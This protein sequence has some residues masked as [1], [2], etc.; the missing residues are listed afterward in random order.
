MNWTMQ[1][2]QRKGNPWVK[3]GLAI[4]VGLAVVAGLGVYTLHSQANAADGYDTTNAIADA[5]RIPNNQGPDCIMPSATPTAKAGAPTKK[6]QPQAV[7]P[8]SRRRHKPRPGPTKTKPGAPTASPTAADPTTAPT[9]GDPTTAPTS[10]APSSATPLPTCTHGDTPP[11]PATDYIDIRNVTTTVTP[12]KTQRGGSRGTFAVQC[13][14]DAN[15]HHNPDNYIVA[16]GVKDGAHHTHDYVGNL[17]TDADSTDQSLAAGGTTCNFGDKSAYVWPSLRKLGVTGP[18]SG[19]LGGGAEGNVGQ[20]LVPQS[21]QIQFRGNAFNKVVAMPEFLR[22]ITGDAKPLTNGPANVKAQWTCAG[23]TNKITQKYPLCPNGRG[24][25]RIE[26]FPSCW[27]GT[28]LDSAN[29]R[30]H[31]VFP[32]VDGRCPQN[33]KAIPQLRITLTYNVPAGRSFA[34]DSFPEQ[35]HD[36]SSDHSDFENLIPVNVMNGAVSCINGS[37]NC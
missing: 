19:A 8:D 27:D 23:Q 15:Q 7:T 24:V 34:V 16:P 13:G 22:M 37:R 29:H 6:A 5:A 31:V 3:R 12:P 26:D 28:N 10:A 4:A 33:T 1:E 25:T 18:D 20:I 9:T 35:L 2:R 17:T 11:P 30:T 14:V 32:L 21:A 36:P